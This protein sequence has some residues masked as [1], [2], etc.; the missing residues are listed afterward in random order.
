MKTYTKKPATVQAIQYDGTNHN[1]IIAFT[2]GQAKFQ[3]GL[4]SSEDGNGGTQSY[5]TLTLETHENQ[6]TNRAW[7]R[8]DI[9]QEGDFVVEAWPGTFYRQG[10]KFFKNETEEANA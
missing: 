6:G 8:Q 5:S 7:I 2:N 9:I 4:G 10:Q 1:E 3:S